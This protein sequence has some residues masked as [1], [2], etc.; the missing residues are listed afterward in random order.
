M[1]WILFGLLERFKIWRAKIWTSSK[2]QDAWNIWGF[3]VM[4]IYISQDTHIKFYTFHD[5]NNWKFDVPETLYILFFPPKQKTLGI[6]RISKLTILRTRTP[7]L[8]RFK[9][10][11]LEGSKILRGIDFLCQIQAAKIL[12]L[13]KRFRYILWDSWGF[14][15]GFL[16]FFKKGSC[17]V[18]SN[19]LQQTLGFPNNPQ[20]AF[21]DEA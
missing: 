13:M 19:I 21:R 5:F 12:Q 6:H 17:K 2:V 11:P 14:P 10:P 9:T 20:L 3:T 15:S 1:Y 4:Y 8:Y 18:A 16:W 7:L